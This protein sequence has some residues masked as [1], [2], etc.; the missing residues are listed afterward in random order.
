MSPRTHLLVGLPIPFVSLLG[1]FGILSANAWMNTPPGLH[2]RLRRQPDG[3]QRRSGACSTRCSAPQYWH[4]I[5]AAY[6]TR[7][8]L[9]ASVYAVGWLRGAARPLPPARFLVP[10]TVAAIV[11]PIQSGSG[12][13]S[14]APSTSSSRAKFAAIEIVWRPG[15]NRRST[16]TDGCNRTG[17]WTASGFPGSTR[18]WPAS[19]GTNVVQGLAAS[20]RTS[21]P[22]SGR[23]NIAHGVRHHGGDRDRALLLSAWVGL[24]WLRRRDNATS[25]WFYRCAAV[26][27]VASVV[28][29]R[30]RVGHAEVGPATVG[31]PGSTD[32]A[33][34]VTNISAGP[35][36]TSFASRRGLLLDRLGVRRPAVRCGSGGGARTR[37]RR[38]SGRRRPSRRRSRRDQR[39]RRRPG[40]CCWRSRVLL[41]WRGRLRGRL[42]GPDRRERRPRC[43]PAALSGLRDG[44]GLG[45]QQRLG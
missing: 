23:R 1:A 9:V 16:S 14:P 22:A 11:T 10:F 25:R 15:Q 31:R 36:W 28:A 8:F 30:V 34:A 43:P 17:R 6:M 19:A 20:P 24:A 41:R 21:G 3:C 45:G 44:P 26:A 13:S 38:G 4:F 40:S 5:A 39:G 18:S 42:L 7:G 37:R 2:P 33:E 32:G 27:G 35:I 29:R 12:T